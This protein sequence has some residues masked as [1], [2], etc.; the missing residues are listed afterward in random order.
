MIRAQLEKTIR[1]VTAED[2]RRHNIPS[3]GADIMVLHQKRGYGFWVMSI[4]SA[5]TKL[6]YQLAIPP[7]DQANNL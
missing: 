1:L 3:F 6:F 7:P 5:V 4:S 2:K